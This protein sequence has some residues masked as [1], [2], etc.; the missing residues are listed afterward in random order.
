MNDLVHMF[1]P[2]FLFRNAMLASVLMGLLCPL[3]GRHLVFGRTIL[4]GLALPQVSLMGIAFIFLGAGLGWEWCRS[5]HSDFSRALLGSM[6]FT[7]PTLVG[8]AV[9]GRRHVALSEG[10]LA[11][12]YLLALSV[13]NL[14]LSHHAVG[15]SYL[16]DLFHG[17]LLLV[18]SP[19]LVI[20]AGIL[21][22]AS[23]LAIIFRHRILIVL[24]DPEFAAS[25]RIPLTEWHIALALMNGLVIGV[26]V[27]VVGPLVTFGFLVLP[28]MTASLL[29]RSLKTHAIFSSS[30][31]VAMGGVGFYLSFH[32]DLP[33]G[34]CVVAVG[35]GTLLLAKGAE[36]ILLRNGR[37]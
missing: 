34:A 1:S 24:S 9:Y 12:L 5:V 11:F 17:R 37:V 19:A 8:L 31:G 18:S 33:L 29:A 28:V 4:L 7:I 35:C 10:W 26:G 15:E 20:L 14:M 16:E 6:I 23:A 36:I 25:L 27:A 32:H 2:D 22:V 21:S 13:S 3:I 30:T